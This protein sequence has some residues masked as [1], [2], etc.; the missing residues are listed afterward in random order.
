MLLTLL[1]FVTLKIVAVFVEE[2]VASPVTTVAR[3]F[4]TKLALF[5]DLAHLAMEP[6]FATLLLFA[7][8]IIPLPFNE[9]VAFVFT[10]DGE[11]T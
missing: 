9:F 10:E 6:A 5:I 8:M 1:L 2:A 3:A 4:D 7:P 11:I